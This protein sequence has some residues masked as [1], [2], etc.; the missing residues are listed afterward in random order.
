MA[1]KL[2]NLRSLVWP[3]SRIHNLIAT[4]L[5]T[6]WPST[7]LPYKLRNTAR[8]SNVKS[9]VKVINLT[10]ASNCSWRQPIFHSAF[11]RIV[12]F[13]IAYGNCLQS[14]VCFMTNRQLACAGNL[15]YLWQRAGGTLNVSYFRGFQI[16][17]SFFW[18][19]IH[20]D[21]SAVL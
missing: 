11:L 10:L 13:G 16:W 14:S 17:S 1:A 4:Q 5:A 20:D 3:K 8:K 7:Q 19:L 21:D 6:S 12:Y 15:W 2:A 9:S 18:R